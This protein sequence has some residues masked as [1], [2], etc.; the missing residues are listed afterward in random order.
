M[1]T[2]SQGPPVSP[3]IEREAN[4]FPNPKQI[5]REQAEAV[6]LANLAAQGEVGLTSDTNTNNVRVDQGEIP[7]VNAGD[8]VTHSNT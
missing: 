4:P 6:R 2:R 8:D 3:N 1:R 5:A 7:P